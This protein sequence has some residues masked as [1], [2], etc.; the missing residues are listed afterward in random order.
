MGVLPQH[1][2]TALPARAKLW[3]IP[4]FGVVA[5]AYAGVLPGWGW[6]WYSWHPLCMMAAFVALSSLAALV[7]KRGGYENTKTH[8]LLMTCAVLFAAFGWYV[9][10]SNK[11]MMAKPHLTSWHSWFGVLALVTYGALFV[12]GLGGLH[13]DVGLRTKDRS[14]RFVHKWGGRV[15]IATAWSAAVLGFFYMHPNAGERVLFAAPLLLASFSLLRD[16]Y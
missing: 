14:L 9:I 11:N 6:A 7:K 1:T 5:G 4:L 13:P 10:Y 12:I 8:A 3:P 2:A 15:A 16:D